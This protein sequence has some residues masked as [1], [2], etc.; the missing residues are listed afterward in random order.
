MRLKMSDECRYCLDLHVIDD[1]EDILYECP[2]QLCHKG[3][4]DQSSS[5]VKLF[6]VGWVRDDEYHYYVPSVKLSYLRNLR[7]MKIT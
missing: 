2:L 7:D 1:I 3:R 4:Y 5:V 6:R